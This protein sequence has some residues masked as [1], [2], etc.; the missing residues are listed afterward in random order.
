M[1]EY[2]LSILNSTE[3]IALG[4]KNASESNILESILEFLS[5]NSLIT[6]IAS[7]FVFLSGLLIMVVHKCFQDCS[8]N[9]SKWLIT[10]VKETFGDWWEETKALLFSLAKVTFLI[11]LRRG[12][13]IELERIK[14]AM[15]PLHDKLKNAD[16]RADKHD[17]NNAK[18]RVGKLVDIIYNFENAYDRYQLLQEMTPETPEYSSNTWPCWVFVL[19]KLWLLKLNLLNPIRKIS[20]AFAVA[21]VIHELEKSDSYQPAGNTLR[22]KI[23]IFPQNIF[24]PFVPLI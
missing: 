8:A 2:L 1:V 4:I 21:K 16:I 12:L 18:K 15:G 14:D 7:M 3:L 6:G 19:K 9:T 10:K 20:I 13:Y 24:I 5:E 22:L 17:D 11:L 23:I